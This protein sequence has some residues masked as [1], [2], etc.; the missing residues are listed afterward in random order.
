MCSTLD[1]THSPP[2]GKLKHVRHIS[3]AKRPRKKHRF[4]G[5]DCGGWVTGCSGRHGAQSSEPGD[6]SASAPAARVLSCIGM[7]HWTSW[8]S[9]DPQPVECLGTGLL[10]VSR[11]C[12]QRTRVECL[13]PTASSDHGQAVGMTLEVPRGGMWHKP[14]RALKACRALRARCKQMSRCVVAKSLE[15]SR[16]AQTQAFCWSRCGQSDSACETSWSRVTNRPELARSTE[17]LEARSGQS[18]LAWQR[19]R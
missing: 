14:C 5:L 4:E 16:L 19:D 15:R 1:N 9:L 3:K 18:G 6:A 13:R 12:R 2:S 10:R 11:R 7:L 17:H 8:H